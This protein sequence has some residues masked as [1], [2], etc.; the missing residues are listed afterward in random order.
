[1]GLALVDKLVRAMG[2]TI[3]VVSEVGK[4]SEFIVK[5]PKC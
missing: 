4:G 1:L 5:L 2:G 3:E